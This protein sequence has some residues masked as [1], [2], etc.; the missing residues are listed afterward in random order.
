M[1][2]AFKSMRVFK[3]VR[4]YWTINKERKCKC[5]V[6]YRDYYCKKDKKECLEMKE[7]KEKILKLI[8]LKIQLEKYRKE[9]EKER[10]GKGNTY[11]IPSVCERIDDI[12]KEIE[13]L[14][15]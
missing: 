8:D 2:G 15:L 4:N 7:L 11:Y 12:E 10:E 3:K 5:D 14:R 9:Y 13:G 6:V 1:G